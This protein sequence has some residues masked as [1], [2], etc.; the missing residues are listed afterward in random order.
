[1]DPAI[2]V[3][4]DADGL[5]DDY[6][7]AFGL[8]DPAADADNDG[9][10]NLQEYQLG[11]RPDYFDTDGDLLPDGWEVEYRLDLLTINSIDSDTDG[12]GLD[13]FDE[14][15]NGTDPFTADSDGDG[16]LD[17]AEVTQGSDPGNHV[18]GGHPPAPETTQEVEFGIYGDYASWE[19]TVK[20]LGPDERVL[21]LS[22]AAP[23]GRNEKSL[24]L[25]RNSDYEVGMRWLATIEGEDIDW[26]CWEA[27]VDRQPTEATFDSYDAARLAG[28]AEFFPVADGW[29][30]DNRQGLL[31]SHVHMNANEGGNVAGSRVAYLRK[32]DLISPAGNPDNDPVNN[33]I[34]GGDGTGTVPNGANEF[35]FSTASNGVLTIQFKAEVGGGSSVLNAIKDRVTFTIENIGQAPSWNAANPGGKASVSGN[36]LVATA[37]FTGLPENNSDFGKKKVEL[38]FDGNVL[39]KSEIEVFFPKHAKNHPGTN[40]GTDPNWFYYWKDGKVCGIPTDAIYDPQPG[41]YGYVRPGVDRIL[42]L[43]DLAAETNSGPEVY[44]S[45]TIKPGTQPPATYGSLTVTGIGEGI[46]CA[47]ETV[48]HELYHLTIY[49]DQVG[50]SD[51][52]GDLV[53]DASEPNLTGVDS[54]ISN[55]DTFS[56]GGSYSNYGDNEVR[57]RKKELSLSFTIYPEKDW[58]NPGCQSKNQFGPN[59]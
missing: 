17:G 41:V 34:D 26:Y 59:L 44:L 51:A 37:T 11:T 6:E 5:P 48:E 27:K 35:T 1:M 50:K 43:G 54:S 10:S 7:T 15:L 28:A 56:M 25:H 30:A 45:S 46:L 31:T 12:D 20:G 14:Y 19:M 36:Y 52:D 3:D 42:R 58:A 29:I 32:V 57:C 40:A 9:L 38:L 2:N 18:D 16:T 4:T 24:K 33:P 21:K 49:D 22:T 39:E 47:A 23:G 55:P 13:L 53:A 8:T